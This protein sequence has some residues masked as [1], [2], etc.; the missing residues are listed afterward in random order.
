MADFAL[1]SPIHSFMLDLSDRITRQ[2][3]TKDDWSEICSNLPNVPP[4][5]KEASDYLDKFDNVAVLKD[6]QD[7]LDNRPQHLESQLIHEC[8]MNWY[9]VARYCGPYPNFVP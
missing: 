6:L 2:L 1:C 8:L 3:F 9:V 7:L 4:Y 5:S